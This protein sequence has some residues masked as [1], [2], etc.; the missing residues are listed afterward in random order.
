MEKV[1]ARKYYAEFLPAC[2]PQ[3]QE[4]GGRGVRFASRS[5]LGVTM[6][7][8]LIVVAAVPCSGA[9]VPVRVAGDRDGCKPYLAL[10]EKIE[11]TT[12]GQLT[13]PPLRAF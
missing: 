13:I 11:L 6:A 5:A 12:D 3:R 4:G 7:L 1:L 10:Q 9:E 2:L 8:G